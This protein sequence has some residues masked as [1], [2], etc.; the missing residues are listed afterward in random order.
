MPGLG[1]AAGS[2]AR[3]QM[4][5]RSPLSY[6]WAFFRSIRIPLPLRLVSTL[7]PLLT[8]M[9]HR[10]RPPFL[11]TPFLR[12]RWVA[13]EHINFSLQPL[14]HSFVCTVSCSLRCTVLC[15]I[16]ERHRFELRLC[17]ELAKRSPRSLRCLPGV[18]FSWLS[19]LGNTSP[20]EM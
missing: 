16:A 2:R 12:L 9:C 6:S 10:T 17:Q 20:F 11:P 8:L 7:L 19:H 3:E 5:V 13:L 4:S 18:W 14:L 15:A 1:G